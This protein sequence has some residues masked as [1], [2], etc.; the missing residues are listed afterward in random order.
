MLQ[1]ND[2]RDLFKFSIR[3]EIEI[4]GALGVE[5]PIPQVFSSL[6]HCPC[7]A[8]TSGTIY[9][10]N[11]ALACF[12]FVCELRTDLRLIYINPLLKA[13]SHNSH[14]PDVNYFYSEK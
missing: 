14:A 4:V 10:H 12:K 11:S 13:R 1:L 3:A 9:I 5:I 8:D 6:N 2:S 7:L